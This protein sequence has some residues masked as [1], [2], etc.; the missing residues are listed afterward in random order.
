[1][2]CQL[3]QKRG[4]MRYNTKALSEDHDHAHKRTCLL[5]WFCFSP[6]PLNSI[7]LVLFFSHAQ[8]GRYAISKSG[9]TCRS[10]I[11][12][13]WLGSTDGIFHLL[14]PYLAREALLGTHNTVASYLAVCL[15]PDFK[16]STLLSSNHPV[17]IRA[18]TCVGWYRLLIQSPLDR[19]NEN[20]VHL[21]GD[22]VKAARMLPRRPVSF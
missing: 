11:I 17:F 13:P 3:C 1:M 19:T 10:T 5:F 8:F 15:I 21:S 18:D 12:P 4:C 6:L 2:R 7:S 22:R 20:L 9:L 14:Q 16:R